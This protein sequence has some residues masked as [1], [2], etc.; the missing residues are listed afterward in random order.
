ML[1]FFIVRSD[2]G[3]KILDRIKFSMPV[4]KEININA[5]LADFT[6]TFGSLLNTGVPVLKSLEI[7]RD[8][9]SNQII[10][11]ILSDLI[12]QVREG[13]TIADCFNKN[14]LFPTIMVQL[15]AAG[16]NSGEL[17]VMMDKIH[18]Y[19]K[20]RVDDAVNRFTAVMEPA[21][22]VVLGGLVLIMAMSIFLPMFN[23]AGAVR[24]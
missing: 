19:F 1:M 12:Q 11:P 20:E 3:K 21:M 22:L 4:I 9:T 16:E 5:A 14:P 18:L 24:R 2:Q 15:T 6:S 23:L 17:D 13:A 10:R 7:C 8:S